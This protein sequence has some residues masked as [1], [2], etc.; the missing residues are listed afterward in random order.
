[1]MAALALVGAAACKA[2]LPLA[3]GAP[4]AGAPFSVTCPPSLPAAAFKPNQVPDG[5]VG[6][7]PQ[8][9]RVSGAG[10]LWGPPDESGYLKPDDAKTTGPAGRQVNVTRWRLDVPH[11][12]ETWA[13]CAYGPLQLAKRVPPGAVECTVSS[14]GSHGWF[15]GIVF[16]CK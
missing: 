12:Y 15:D 13:Y 5:W 8:D 16:V 10:L 11:A 3:H 1:M 4:L 7:V 14:T 9:T 6:A 2:G